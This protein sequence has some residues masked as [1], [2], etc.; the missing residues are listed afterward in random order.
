ME[1]KPK[2]LMLK[3]LPGSGKTTYAQTLEGR[4]WVRT[5]KDNMRKLYFPDY[6]SKD[7]N[8]IVMLEDEIIKKAL[9]SGQY[10]VSDN[11]H[12]SPHHQARLEMIA[13]ECNADFELL[14]IDTPL[15][16]CIARNNKRT[17]NRV[18]IDVI[19]GM[20]DKYIAPLRDEEIEYDD[21][22]EECIIVDIDGTIAVLGDRSPYD[23]ASCGGDTVNDAVANIVNMAYGHGYKVILVT[24]RSKEHRNI[25]RKW[26]EENGINY[27][28]IYF[29]EEGSKEKDYDLKEGLY[30]EH[31]RNKY[32]VKY[33]IE[34][35]PRNC[36]MWRRLG[37]EV[38]QIGEPYNEF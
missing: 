7:E 31:I 23:T 18:P 4:G 24:G 30:R 14:F 15:E 12:F 9:N 38:L 13:K 10:V 20:Y 8:T 16:E 5:N 25:T 11:T 26:L 2:L 28:K 33:V 29:R 19:L 1:S 32:N 37:L 3:G 17:N 36:R 34:D 22:L 6:T 27:D 35:R 21:N